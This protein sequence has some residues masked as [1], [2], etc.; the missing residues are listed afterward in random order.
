MRARRAGK[1]I[2]A[3]KESTGTINKRLRS[4]GLEKTHANRWMPRELLF[5][6]P[7]AQSAVLLSVIIFEETLGQTAARTAFPSCICSRRGA[8]SPASRWTRA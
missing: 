6:H 3:A 7:W 1:G 8:S 5:Y 4:I 2:L